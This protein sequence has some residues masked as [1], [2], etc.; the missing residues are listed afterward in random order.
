MSKIG[1]EQVDLSQKP[2]QE[3]F[4]QA[5]DWMNVAIGNG[6]ELGQT[7]FLAFEGE[8]KDL[9]GFGVYRPALI[10]PHKL[11]MGA[12]TV[13]PEASSQFEVAEELTKH[14][15]SKNGTP[16]METEVVLLYVCDDPLS[17]VVEQVGAIEGAVL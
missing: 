14:I 12:W 10:K 4:V 6:H 15:T 5:R 13:G 17:A 7:A 16:A 1:I 9:A 3:A 11:I 2:H 8:G